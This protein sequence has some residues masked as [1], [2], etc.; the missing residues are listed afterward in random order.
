MLSLFYL[1]GIYLLTNIDSKMLPV[2]ANPELVIILLCDSN[3][4]VNS[5]KFVLLKTLGTNKAS[6]VTISSGLYL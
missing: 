6:G 4:Y 1:I 3:F 5:N 2:A